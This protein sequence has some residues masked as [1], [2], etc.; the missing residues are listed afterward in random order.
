MLSFLLKCDGLVVSAVCSICRGGDSVEV[1]E[2]KRASRV[3]KDHEV[4][5]GVRKKG[6]GWGRCKLRVGLVESG[7][8]GPVLC[9]RLAGMAHPGRRHAPL[10]E[11]SSAWSPML[12]RPVLATNPQ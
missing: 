2:R 9:G 8:A 6:T 4:E 3:H 5:K 7:V 12:F 11:T 1:V 10:G